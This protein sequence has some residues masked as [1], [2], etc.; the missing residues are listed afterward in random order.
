MGIGG[1]GFNLEVEP[2]DDTATFEIQAGGLIIDL[3]VGG[4]PVDG[5]VIGGRLVGM[6][7]TDPSVKVGDDE[8]DTGGDVTFSKAELFTDVY[9]WPDEG[10]HFLG[11]V[12]PAA[13]G[14]N[15]ES[16]DSGESHTTMGGFGVTLGAGWEGWVGKEWSIGGMLSLNWAWLED[17]EVDFLRPTKSGDSFEMVYSGKATAKLFVPTLSFAATFQ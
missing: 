16:M 5:F 10:V 6:T 3:G 8:R 15:H 1:G 17:E 13:I 4:T 7:G 11:A 2:A 9:P 12:G 14:Y